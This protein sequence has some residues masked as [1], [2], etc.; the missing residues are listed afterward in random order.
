MR[1]GRG[2]IRKRNGRFQARWYDPETRRERGKTFDTQR[3]ASAFLTQLQTVK[4]SIRDVH[5]TLAEWLPTYQE[6][7]RQGLAQKTLN[8]DREAITTLYNFGSFLL[9]KPLYAITPNDISVY[10]NNLASIYSKRTVQM[11]VGFLSGAFRKAVQE[12]RMQYNPC[13]GVPIR[14]QIRPQ[15][16]REFSDDDLAHLQNLFLKQVPR[17]EAL[18]SICWTMMKTAMRTGEARG[19]RAEDIRDGG[20]YICRALDQNNQIGPVKAGQDRFVPVRDIK[21]WERLCFV[22]SGY[23]FHTASGR[24]LDHSSIGRFVRHE[25]P[26]HSPHDFRHTFIT[27]A[28]RQGRNLKALSAL[29]GDSITTLLKHYSHVRTED[30]EFL[31][32]NVFDF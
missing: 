13:T 26:G 31:V 9:D 20:I 27:R 6:T 19:L 11:R 15:R 10:I 5:T 28:V 32:E 12:G 18:I 4:E 29:T 14:G 7:Y 23:I 22:K 1:G 8:I 16:N 17:R 24:A 30:V 2:F 21:L 25:F 3:E